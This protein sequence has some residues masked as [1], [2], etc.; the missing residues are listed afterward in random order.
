ME[1]TNI[2]TLFGGLALFLYGMSMMSNGLEVAAGNRMK[3]ILEKLTTNRFL[4]VGVGALITA[5]IQS[6]SATTVMVVG[7][8]SSGLMTLRSAAWVIMGANIGTT[9]TGQLIALDITALAPVFAFIGV[10]MITFMKSKQLDAIGSVIAGLGVL[11][12]GMEM[13]STSMAPLRTMPEF[14]NMITKFENPFIGIL[15]GALFTAIIQ[16]SSASVGILQAFAV[17]G[18]I[19]LPTAIYVL[20]GQNIGTC[21]TAVIASFGTERNAKRA[22]TIHLLFNIIGTAIFVTISLLT[23]FEQWVAAFT[24]EN[25]PAQIANVHTIFNVGT[26]LLLLPFGKQIVDMT[27]LILP[28]TKEENIVRTSHLDFGLFDGEYRLGTSALANAQIFQE[29]QNMLTNVI[30]VVENSFDLL[31][32]FDE[33]LFKETNKIEKYID[34]LNR[35]II[36]FTTMTLSFELPSSG[37]HAIGLF[38]KVSSDL[39]R[40]SDHA[41]NIAERAEEMYAQGDM[42]SDGAQAEIATMKSLT[43]NILAELA[44]QNYAE[45]N[46]LQA[47]VN[48]LEDDIDES[49]N[50]F[51]TNQLSRLQ[52]KSCSVENSIQYAK[53][54]TDFERIGDHAVNIANNFDEIQATVHSMRML[55]TEQE[56]AV[57]PS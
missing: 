41:I 52:K 8:V 43:H 48:V 14:V 22:T 53:V 49:Y 4:G 56:T 3:G 11:F 17:S 32:H 46:Q 7:F 38:V 16:S 57:Q 36:R 51:G 29:I 55:H 45:F 25:V 31:T 28:R 2:F 40:I 24:P 21:I 33:E 34:H 30:T 13:M 19:T 12:M 27:Y 23:P 9:I 44:V 15:V 18:V 47:R 42:F 35:E 20:F 39:E 5:V 26:T 1:I 50:A 37:T 54:L 6:S 10:A